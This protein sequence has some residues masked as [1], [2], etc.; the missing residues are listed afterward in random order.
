MSWLLSSHLLDSHLHQF[1]CQFYWFPDSYQLIFCSAVN[2]L[3]TVIT[4]IVR[5]FLIS[6]YSS[7][8]YG[9][10]SCL[11]EIYFFVVRLAFFLLA[12]ST[13]SWLIWHWPEDGSKASLMRLHYRSWPRLLHCLRHW[14][15]TKSRLIRGPANNK[16][17]KRKNDS[18]LRETSRWP[19]INMCTKG[20]CT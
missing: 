6:R 5:R 14:A 11:N 18:K 12:P 1:S 13:H 8:Y 17:W 2:F 20:F 19:Q 9:Q 4:E 3:S 10:W 16:K 15:R 7:Y